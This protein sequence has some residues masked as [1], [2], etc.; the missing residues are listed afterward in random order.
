MT[1]IHA[2]AEEMQRDAELHCAAAA[3]A[4]PKTPKVARTD[5]LKA[6]ARKYPCVLADEKPSAC[7]SSYGLCESE[8][9]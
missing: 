5:K 4:I 1:N 7:A 9:A 3:L 2:A 8:A 6:A